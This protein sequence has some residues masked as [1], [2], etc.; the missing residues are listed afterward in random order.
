MFWVRVALE[1]IHD[2]YTEEIIVRENEEITEAAVQKF[3]E[4]GIEMVKIAHHW[5]CKTDRGVCI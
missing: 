2:P 1:N 5:T 4:V 3:E